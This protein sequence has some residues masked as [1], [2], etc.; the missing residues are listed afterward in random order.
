MTR[1]R[2]Q[3]WAGIFI[4]MLL[5]PSPAAAKVKLQTLAAGE[6]HSLAIRADGSL[7][8]WGR[9]DYGQLGLGDTTNRLVPIR[10]GTASDWVAVAAGD[11]HSLALKAD[12]SLYAWGYNNVGQ[13]GLGDTFNRN[14]PSRVGFL[15]RDWVAVAAGASHTLAIK[16]NGSLYAWGFN[17][18]GQLGQGNKLSQTSPVQVTGYSDWVAL[19]AGYSHS[20]ALRANGALYAWGYNNSGQL[21]LG[22]TAEHLLPALVGTVDDGYVAVTAGK[23][24]TLAIRDRG[25]LWAWGYNGDGELGLGIPGDQ[26]IP[27]RVGE[28]MNWV[29]VTGGGWHAL[30]LQADGTLWAW[31]NNFSGQLG[32]E[33]TESHTT[34]IQVGTA[35][36][37]AVVAAG[38]EH[39][40]GCRAD[41]TLYVWGYNAS[42]Q[43]G[44]GDAA[45]RRTPTRNSLGRVPAWA[46]FS[47]G[48]STTL[49]IRADASLWAWGG[50]EFGQLGLGDTTGRL[51]QARVGAVENMV[52]IANGFHTL[53]L[54]SDGSLWA[55]GGNEFGQ[56]GLAVGDTTDRHVPM[57]VGDENIWAKVAVGQYHSLATMA[58]GSLWAWGNN[59]Y[60]QLGLA[61]SNF[62]SKQVPTRVGDLNEW[63]A[64][65]AGRYHSL[66]IRA[67]GFLWAWGDNSSGQLG[68][69]DNINR[70]VPTRVGLNYTWVTAAAGM[71]H[72]LAITADGSLYAWG[73]NLFGQ[74]G[75]GNIDAQNAPKLVGTGWKAV[76]AGSLHSLGVKADGSLWAWGDNFYCQLGLGEREN[77][78]EIAPV[79]V[80]SAS[81]WVA[82]AAGT[83]FSLGQRADGSL[84][85]WGR[86]HVGQLGLGDTVDR[87]TP[88]RIRIPRPLPGILFQLLAD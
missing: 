65:A 30:G 41:G 17:D 9:N 24:H 35:T 58:D 42:G 11:L 66:G 5:W 1:W 74:L 40:L 38:G 10:V 12:G 32:H 57:R 28:G 34:P 51:T 56:L 86:N 48:E 13:L 78:K 33:G 54:R 25:T 36:D 44:Q 52:S 77:L 22:D 82:V 64:V 71:H 20:L 49:G 27:T 68:L 15:V 2:F 45:I 76:A 39:S 21:G 72:S 84:C 16:A 73:A 3:V 83:D 43:L 63:V 8:A 62:T 75:L 81:D 31:G 55:W 29:A 4:L 7:W 18:Q 79:R 67:N 37:W 50:N 61:L 47:A 14:V 6:F 87:N 59:S 70:Q 60:G 80:G 85:V 53:G 69:L 46:R 19:A 26:T 88:T 23:Y